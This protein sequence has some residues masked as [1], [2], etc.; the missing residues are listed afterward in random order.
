M[1]RWHAHEPGIAAETSHR[2]EL[3]NKIAAWWGAFREKAPAIIR[4]FRNQ[5]EEWNLSDWMHDHLQAIDP[6]LMWEFGPGIPDGYRLVIT[7]ETERYLRPLVDQILDAAPPLTGWS[8]H[9]WRLPEDLAMTHHTVEARCGSSWLARGCRVT[10]GERFRVDIAFTYPSEF[11]A[12]NSDLAGRQSFIAAETLLGEEQLDHWNGSIESLPAANDD[13]PLEEAAAAFARVK[14]QMIAS[15]PQGLCLERAPDAEWTGWE[16]KPKKK[17]EYQG[18]LDLF[19]GRS[20]YPEVWTDAHSRG[21]FHSGRF[22]AQE[23]FCYLKLDGKEGIDQ[24]LFP[25]KAAIED[26]IDAAL[27]PHKLGCTIGG[28]T[29]LR[30][31]YIDLALTDWRA[32]ANILR[33]LLRKGRVPKRSWL[34]FFDDDWAHEWF[35]IYPDTPEPPGIGE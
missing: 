5:G 18:Q 12:E 2:H 15:R 8:F 16:L 35:G 27:V 17:D 11:L 23:T 9:A 7:P 4:L 33:A 14:A 28:G 6:H 31:S 3:Q 24:E 10:P 26:A 21:I 13:L 25:D 30:Y 22:S 34:L 32:A 19:Y 29:G 20:F 1:P